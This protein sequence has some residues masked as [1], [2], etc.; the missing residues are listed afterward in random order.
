[1]LRII[2]ILKARPY[3]LK[4]I[5]KVFWC[6][7]LETAL[8]HLGIYLIQYIVEQCRLYVTAEYRNSFREALA[9][10]CFVLKFIA[11]LLVVLVLESA[12]L[13]IGAVMKVGIQ[14]VCQELNRGI[15]NI[16]PPGVKGG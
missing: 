13:I 5:L 6:L 11:L 9:T 1:M 2:R 12:I 4:G 3:I 7:V 14:W 8:I 10:I 16:I 15:I